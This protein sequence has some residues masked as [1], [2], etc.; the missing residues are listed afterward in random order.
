MCD[1][2]SRARIWHLPDWG[3]LPSSA[4][5]SL[6][7]PGRPTNA[8]QSDESRECLLITHK[9]FWLIKSYIVNMSYIY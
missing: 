8:T 6:D 1:P 3:P 2:A 4:L 9:F 5:R 7:D